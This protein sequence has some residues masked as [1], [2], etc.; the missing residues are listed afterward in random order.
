MVN[1]M[2][3]MIEDKFVTSAGSTTASATQQ[4]GPYIMRL[5]A[6]EAAP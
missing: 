1:E 6:L 2:D 4:P 5:V 3:G